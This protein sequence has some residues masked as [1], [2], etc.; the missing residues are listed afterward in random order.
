MDRDEAGHGVESIRQA[1]ARAGV[2]GGLETQVVPFES[3]A[4]KAMVSWITEQ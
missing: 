1:Y 2:K 3:D 4:R